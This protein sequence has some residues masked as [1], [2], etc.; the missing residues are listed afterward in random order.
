M[1]NAYLAT[2]PTELSL[3]LNK[4][5]VIKA[6]AATI[7]KSLVGSLM[8]LTTTRPDLMFSV[9]LLSRFM[10]SPQR[11]H[12][13]DGKRILRYILGTIDHGIFHYKKNVDNI[14]SYWLQ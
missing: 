13:E 3:K 10:A 5:D 11:S 8:Y 9:I 7:Y 12:S 2:T 1:E 4:H 14:S 6:L